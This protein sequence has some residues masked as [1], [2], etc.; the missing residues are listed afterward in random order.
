MVMTAIANTKDA[1]MELGELV[2]DLRKNRGLTQVELS[3]I[4]GVSS[5]LITLI[6]NGKHINLGLVTAAKLD[7]ALKAR[8][9]IFDFLYKKLS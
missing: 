5:N 6:E 7:K 1:S 2:R 9:Q 4:S 3:Q 8:R